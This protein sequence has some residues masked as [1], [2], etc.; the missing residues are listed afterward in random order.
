MN[1]TPAIE[2]DCLAIAARI[3]R[4]DVDHKHLI[5]GVFVGHFGLEC[6]RYRTEKFRKRL[7]EIPER[8]VGVYEPTVKPEWIV[9]DVA[10]LEIA[11]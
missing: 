4:A 8:L 6:V 1:V 7:S 9:A 11:P 5:F 2:K 10:A 3:N